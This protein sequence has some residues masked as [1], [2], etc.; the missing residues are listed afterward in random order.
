MLHGPVLRISMR[1]RWQSL[2]RQ[3]LL[4]AGAPL[5]GEVSLS[6]LSYL[7][8]DHGCQFITAST[9]D[10]LEQILDWERRGE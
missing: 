4:Q 7:Q 8:F 2:S 6:A 9:P 1:I 5:P 10:A 3:V